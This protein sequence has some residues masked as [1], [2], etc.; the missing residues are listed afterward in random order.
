MNGVAPG[1]VLTRSTPVHAAHVLQLLLLALAMATSNYARTALGPLQESVR[2][3]LGLSDNQVALLQGPAITWPVVFAAIPLG[4]LVD[5]HSRARVL[6]VFVAVV[7]LG[8]VA[9]A[10][11]GSFTMLLAARCV[12]GIA[13][14]AVPIA[15]LSLVADWYA[16]EWRGRAKI[17]TSIGELAGAS[18][19]FALG[20]ILLARLGSVADAWQTTMLWL[21][22]PLV[23]I[24][25]AMLALQE[26]GRGEARRSNSSTRGTLA[27]VWQ[28]RS[29]I[30][31]LLTG[32]IMVGTAYSAVVTWTVPALTRT[33]DLTP[34]RTGSIMGM[35]LLVSGIA[36]PIAGGALADFCHRTGGPQRTMTVLSGLAL[37]SIPAG[38][39]VMLP[40][41]SAASALLV[42]FLTLISVIGIT[43]MTLTTIVIPNEL[44]GLCLSILIAAGLVFGVGLAPLAVSLLSGVLGGPAMIGKALAII[45]VATGV[46][47][48]ISF[49]WGR[50]Y[51]TVSRC[52]L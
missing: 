43:E 14:A 52:P 50:R 44:R 46:L 37:L 35:V 27:E 48:A 29:V 51:L 36:G 38:V 28:Y 15:A 6:A 18:A 21:A 30:A 31:P 26:P 40:S 12:V 24:A 16:P 7:L 41:V 47:G 17:V 10:F 8:T 42:L 9:T 1:S 22:G 3:A 23:L 19:V 5:R 39:F 32:K 20:G 33:F 49:G 2:L 25:F 13:A 34:D 45:C 4:L 11:A